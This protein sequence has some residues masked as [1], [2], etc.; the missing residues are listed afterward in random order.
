[1][2]SYRMMSTKILQ[3]PQRLLCDCGHLTDIP[4]VDGSCSSDEWWM[5]SF[6]ILPDIDNL[7]KK[8]LCFPQLPLMQTLPVMH[9]VWSHFVKLSWTTMKLMAFQ[10]CNQFT[11]LIFNSSFSSFA[12]Q[13]T[14]WILNN[15]PK[16]LASNM[17]PVKWI[18]IS[19][20]KN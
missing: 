10:F 17:R 19:S 8:V 4:G 7:G 2:T 16:L 18:V 11:V 6:P 20:V 3:F 12:H 14:G 13:K 1:M 9:M 15:L 5:I